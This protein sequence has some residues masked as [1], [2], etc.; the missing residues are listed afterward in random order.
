MIREERESDKRNR[1]VEGI[2]VRIE[3]QATG[4]GSVVSKSTKVALRLSQVPLHLSVEDQPGIMVDEI[5][6][7]R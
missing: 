6:E 3:E 2:R 4:N 5:Q 1:K 7:Y